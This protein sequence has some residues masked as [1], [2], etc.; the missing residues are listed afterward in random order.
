[1]ADI[2][3]RRTAPAGATA[4]V[5]GA[6]DAAALLFLWCVVVEYTLLYL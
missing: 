2:R 3:P 1:M 5:P 4:S 6:W